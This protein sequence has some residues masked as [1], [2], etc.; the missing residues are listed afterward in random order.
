MAVSRVSFAMTDIQVIGAGLGRTGTMSLKRA[1]EDLGYNPYH[2]ET[3]MENLATHAPLWYAWGRA[4]LSEDADAIDATTRDLFELWR[5]T[6]INATTDFPACVLY[7][8]L[9]RE[10][11]N[12]KVVLSVRRSGEKWAR[13]FAETISRFFPIFQRASRPF[14]WIP[15]VARFIEGE[16]A[17][18]S[19]FFGRV[20]GL[21][22]YATNDWVR[23]RPLQS[24]DEDDMKA[25]ASAH[26]AWKERVI[27]TVP[28]EKLLIYYPGDGYAPLCDFLNI[29]PSLCPSGQPARAWNT[30]ARFKRIIDVMD[31]GS[32]VVPFVLF[33]IIARLVWGAARS[34]ASRRT[35]VEKKKTK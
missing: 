31:I 29:E 21:E 27:A 8:E 19:A 34:L 20:N 3:K 33:V 28:A 24:F 11:P 7:E 15:P 14:M 25:F 32:F 10:Y 23:Y 35:A 16:L 12:A 2:M 13:S 4:V 5:T 22:E 1:L 17:F 26:D 6:G 18:H 30:R 9:M